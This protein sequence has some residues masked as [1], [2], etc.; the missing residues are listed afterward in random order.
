MRNCAS[1]RN[2]RTHF[3]ILPIAV[4]AC[5]ACS[6]PA[7]AQVAGPIGPPPKFDLKKIPVKP[8]PGAPPMPAD[9]MIQRFTQNEDSNKKAYD[10][11]MFDQNVKVEELVT[12]GGTYD[13]NGQQYKKPDGEHYEQVLGT[14]TSNLRYTEF[15]LSD[16]KY[17]AG[18]PLF[19]LTSA[20]A[21]QYNLDYEGTEK[22]DQI[23]T[24]IFGVHPK[25]LGA[26]PL[27]DG[28]VWV[29]DQDFSIV[30]S[31][32]HFVTAAGNAG[33][34]FPFQMFEIYR[35]NLTGHLW[36]PTYIRSDSEVKTPNGS[37]PIRLVIRSSNFRPN[38]T[39]ASPSAKSSSPAGSI[40]LKRISPA[41]EFLSIGRWSEP[42][43]PD[44]P[45]AA[46]LNWGRGPSR[47]SPSLSPA[48][49]SRYL[50]ACRPR[51]RNPLALRE[52]T[53]SRGAAAR[54]EV[55]AAPHPPR[56]CTPGKAS[57]AQIALAAAGPFFRP[58]S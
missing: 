14:P 5:V 6:M 56:R 31:Y 37:V 53:A 18:M 29:D 3:W 26:K 57:A 27:F 38:A 40:S 13:F 22:L 55:S 19:F 30:K 16:V 17:L 35:E 32:G 10:A 2:M 4:L 43:R 41:T 44:A 1:N 58:R 36:L 39:P 34:N 8:N 21:S 11:D 42:A 28:V 47:Q 48:A 54:D 20:D 50:P 23:D 51:K 7:S 46:A 12:N 45:L 9:Q 49:P 24:Y 25:Q 15:S 52:G 33:N